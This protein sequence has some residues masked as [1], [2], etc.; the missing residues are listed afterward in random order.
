MVVE[1]R[2]KERRVIIG[3]LKK[4][5][6]PEESVATRGAGDAK[7]RRLEWTTA[8]TAADSGLRA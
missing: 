3:W 7:L 8:S 1:I 2:T 6:K 4:L 5:K